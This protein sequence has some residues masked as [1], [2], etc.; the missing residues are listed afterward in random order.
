MNINPYEIDKAIARKSF[1]DFTKFT[2]SGYQESDHHRLICEHLEAF[3]RRDIKNLII[4]CPPRHG[5]S[6]LVSRRLPAYILGKNPDAKII[7]SSYSSDLSSRMNRDVQRIIDSPEYRELFPK[8]YLSSKNIRSDAKGSYVR[9]SDMFEMVGRQ[10]AYRSAGVGGGITGMGCDFGLID[11]PIKDA[12]EAN[13]PRIRQ[14]VWE[15]FITTFLT[16]LEE[17]AGWLTT[18]TRWHEDDLVGRIMKETNDYEIL[19]LKAINDGK[20]L[21]PVKYDIDF[22]NN[23]KKILGTKA[24]E[25][26]YQQNPTP[27]GGNII[28]NDW[29]H[30]WKV[31]PPQYQETMMSW[32]LAFKGTSTSDYVVGQMWGRWGAD[33]F[34][35]DQVRGKWDFTQTVRQVELFAIKHMNYGRI[36]I[37]DKANGP[38]VMNVLRNKIPGIVPYKPDSDKVSRLHSVTPVFESGNVFIPPIDKFDWVKEYVHELTSFPSAKHDDQVDATTQALHILRK[39]TTQQY[40]VSGSS[41]FS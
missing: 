6:E 10:G 21:W 15:W 32:D 41:I 5:K 8:S 4:T 12:E 29:I 33:F 11:D 18:M 28:K 16:R 38:A 13:S 14:K 23:R 22:L 24:F 35:L 1:L 40:A 7:A 19:E 2:Y 20:A 39:R 27:D 9:N 26:L 17:N 36:V 31:L 37:E 30:H 34:L 3:L 25:S